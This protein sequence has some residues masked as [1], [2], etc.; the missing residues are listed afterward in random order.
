MD[1]SGA[2]HQRSECVQFWVVNWASTL[3]LMA[4]KMVEGTTN[5][6]RQILENK[7]KEGDA[8]T[9]RGQQ[10]LPSLPEWTASSGPVACHDWAIASWRRRLQRDG[11][12]FW[13]RRLVS[14]TVITWSYLRLK[15][16][17]HKSLN[18]WNG[19]DWR[20]GWVQC[21]WWQSHKQFGRSNI[22]V[23]SKRMTALKL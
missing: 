10:E 16:L 15:H 1:A 2:L 20:G 22:L 21:C 14:G 18:R 8:E 4:D 3:Q 7:E 9:V 6:Q 13:Q 11:G 12:G 19:R 5:L 23:A 17:H